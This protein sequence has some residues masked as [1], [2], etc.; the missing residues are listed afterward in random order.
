MFPLH[1]GVSTVVQWHHKQL[2]LLPHQ[3][4]SH[5]AA[6]QSCLLL[7]GRLS[8]FSWQLKITSGAERKAR[9]TEWIFQEDNDLEHTY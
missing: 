4:A 2:S 5:W 6:R 8:S 7:L 3:R 1:I 9:S